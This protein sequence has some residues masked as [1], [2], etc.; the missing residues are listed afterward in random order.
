VTDGGK[1]NYVYNY[2]DHLGNIRLSYTQSGT[3]L[4]ILEENHYYP[5]GLK[6]SNY[7]ADKADFDKDETGIFAILKPVERS[8]F[9][10][11]YNGKEFQDELGL[12]VYAYGWRDYDPA[13]ARWTTVD[14][15]LNDLKFTFDDSQVDKDD[16]N[17]VYQALVTKLET[18]EGIFNTNNLNPYGY[19][20]NNPV[21]FYDPDGR[22]PWCLIPIIAMLL[23]SEPAMAPTG[24]PMD[25]QKMADA[26]ATK[27]DWMTSAI[28]IGGVSNAT[29]GT[30]LRATVKNKVK[31]LVRKTNE[32]TTKGR[33]SNNRTADNEAA[34]DHTVRNENGSTTYK[35]KDENPKKNKKGKGFETVKR[36]DYKGAPHVDKKTGTEVPTPHVQENGTTRPAVSGV[37]MPN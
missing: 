5:F 25:G 34:G 16:E 36:V 13:I 21:S 8:E 37:D 4:K 18:A 6:H 2:T 30:I 1:F 27:I 23:A 15:L 14:P 29:A 19:G 3:E 7:N 33:G 22:C 32:K 17:E 24:N 35:V 31:E 20:Y 26:K 12:N 9:Q 11:K 10:Y 28:P